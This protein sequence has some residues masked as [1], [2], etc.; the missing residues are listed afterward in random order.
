MAR[1]GNDFEGMTRT[2]ITCGKEG[3]TLGNT[4]FGFCYGSHGTK[5]ELC[6]NNTRLFKLRPHHPVPC[7]ISDLSSYGQ[8][9]DCH[10]LNV[11]SSTFSLGVVS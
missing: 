8:L 6:F 7:V 4:H 10:H 1:Q 11:S 5:F 9:E 3:F 2:I